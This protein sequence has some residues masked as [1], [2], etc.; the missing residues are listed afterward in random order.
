[1]EWILRVSNGAEPRPRGVFRDYS[2]QL[3]REDNAD[4]GGLHTKAMTTLQARPLDL[5]AGTP[6]L[7]T[8]LLLEPAR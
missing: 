4:F 6:H 3:S 2:L 1:M 8:L 7:E 5:F